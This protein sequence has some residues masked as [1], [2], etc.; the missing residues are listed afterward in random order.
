MTQG[1]HSALR[2]VATQND[3]QTPFRWSQIP[4]VII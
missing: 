1:G 2:I 3:G 4:A